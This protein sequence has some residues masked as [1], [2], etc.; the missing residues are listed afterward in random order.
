VPAGSRGPSAAGGRT[1][2]GSSAATASTT[3]RGARAEAAPVRVRPAEPGGPNRQAR[4][5][6]ARQRREAIRRRQ[7]RRRTYR[8]GLIV[9]AVIVAAA[10]AIGVPIVL[11][12]NSTKTLQQ[13][14]RA[15]GCNGV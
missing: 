7:A 14:E 3:P 13:A 5:D 8:V 6:E 12:H 10:L 15:A 4:K 1:G 11:G 2:S 9:V